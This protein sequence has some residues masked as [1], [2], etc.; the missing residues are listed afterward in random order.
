[1]DK[2]LILNITLLLLQS[3]IKSCKVTSS[4]PTS[5]QEHIYHVLE[6]D[7]DTPKLVLS[8][9]N[10]TMISPDSP[11]QFSPEN[12]SP[13]YQ[14]IKEITNKLKESDDSLQDDGDNNPDY[15]S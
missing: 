14:D 6:T 2:T 12:P 7:R 13:V 3:L 9:Q 8:D 5:I 11:F 1:M 4:T 15:D 10:L